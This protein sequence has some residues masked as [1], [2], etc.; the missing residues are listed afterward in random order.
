MTHTALA[1]KSQPPKTTLGSNLVRDGENLFAQG[2]F[3][4]AEKLFRQV[5]ESNPNHV[6]SLNN[7]GVITHSRGQREG[8]I[9]LFTRALIVDPQNQDASQNMT[10]LLSD[11]SQ[12]ELTSIGRYA[13]PYLLIRLGREGKWEEPDSN[14]LAQ[15][16]GSMDLGQ[17]GVLLE[18]ILRQINP[19][20]E[21]PLVT[22]LKAI[23]HLERTQ[24]ESLGHWI[25]TRAPRRR[26][27]DELELLICIKGKDDNLVRDVA[28]RDGC[29]QADQFLPGWERY[30]RRII[31]TAGADDPFMKLVPQGA[32]SKLGGMR[33][34]IVSD[35]NIA[36][37]CTALMRA[38]NKYTNH[39]ARC[40][41][42]QDDYLSYD[43][44]VLI[45]DGQGAL[46]QEALTEACALIPKADF[47]H[48]GRGIF[49]FPGIDWN[50][51]LSPQ[52]CVI[53]YYGSELR[54]N[55]QAVADFHAK[56]NFQA[57]TAVDL[58]MYRLLPASYYHIQPYMLE[59]DKLPQANWEDLNSLRLCHAPSSA[60][61]RALKRTDLILE[62]MK[63]LSD[64]QPKVESVLIEGVDNKTCLEMKS[65]CHVHIVSLI[66][67]FGLNTIESAAMGLVPITGF[68]NFSR[69]LYPDAPVVGANAT[70]LRAVLQKLIAD[71][72]RAKVIGMACREWARREFNAPALIKKYWYL[73]DLIYHGHSVDYP[74]IF[75]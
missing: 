23:A 57:I 7:M 63:G 18:L 9:A 13:F 70:N 62:T 21:E 47:F 10:A 52:N 16:V 15:A 28:R 65:R 68:D 35:F 6:D 60:N 11:V 29:Y 27:R 25:E 2:D 19:E 64:A 37:Q 4:G 12:R 74:E 56:T 45:R 17:H 38:L 5:L 71:P 3:D 39:M 36:G 58:T 24:I 34:L 33:I 75:K 72:A 26:L 41:I 30:P 32:P 73:Y 48:F 55:G 22:L 44:D 20:F 14:F 66:P 43:R 51:Y 50:Q 67:G 31:S 46:S 61:Y 53:Q 54:D 40:I 49:D 8:A 59:M 69:L 42:C 1:L